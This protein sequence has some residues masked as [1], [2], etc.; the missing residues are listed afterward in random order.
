MRKIKL[1]IAV[2][3]DGYIATPDGGVEWLNQFQI[4]K[5]EDYGYKEIYQ[6][7]DTILMGGRTYRDIVGFGCEWPYKDKTTYIVSRNNVNLT[8]AE[9]VYFITDHVT[10]N[11]NKLK[12][13]TGKDIWLVGGGELVSMLL[14]ANLIDEMHLCYL[15]IV[16][17]QGISLFPNKPKETIW[18]LVSSKSFLSGV[19]SITYTM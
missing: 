9:Q 12:E 3:L 16:L 5:N 2:S 8:P 13:L 17:G 6:S 11:V 14:D 1:Y 10:D 18:K 7:I 4:S 19:I 15:P